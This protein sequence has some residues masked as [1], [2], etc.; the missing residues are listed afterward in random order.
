V[1]LTGIDAEW[2]GLQ[3]KGVDFG[4]QLAIVEMY[5]R[6]DVKGESAKLKAARN[7]VGAFGNWIS[8]DSS[9]RI[10]AQQADHVVVPMRLEDADRMP[11]STA[12]RTDEEIGETKGHSFMP[13]QMSKPSQTGKL[14]K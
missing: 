8:R 3:I 14:S 6:P 10:L 4:V 5:R 2:F 9:D 11:E 1:T 7:G 13:Y 12:R